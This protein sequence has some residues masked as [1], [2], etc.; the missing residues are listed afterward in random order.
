MEKIKTTLIGAG[1]RGK[2]LLKFLQNSSFFEVMAVA[3]PYIEE[4]DIPEIVCYNN[5]EEDYLNMLDQHKPELVFIT[6][7][8]QCH[9]HH[10]IQCVERRCHVALEIKGGLY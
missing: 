7:P 9:V 5:G 1:Y 4:T 8:W 10:A 2:Q 3:D 6:S